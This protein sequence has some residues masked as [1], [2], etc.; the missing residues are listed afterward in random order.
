[1]STL[2][3]L[4]CRLQQRLGRS[5]VVHPEGGNKFTL[6]VEGC[7]VVF[8]P[9]RRGGLEKTLVLVLDLM[10]DGVI[11]PVPAEDD[12]TDAMV[13]AGV[14]FALNSRLGGDYMWPDYIRDLYRKMREAR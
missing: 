10:N 5:V 11:K 2:A 7:H 12:P 9:F 6:K 8:G 1:M 14:M 4:S 3:E 13:R